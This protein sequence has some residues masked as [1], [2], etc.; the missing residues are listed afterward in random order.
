MKNVLHQDS[1]SS[2]P[3]K[4][5]QTVQGKSGLKLVAAALVTISPSTILLEALN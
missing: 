1:V 2:Q 4:T 5:I 3:A